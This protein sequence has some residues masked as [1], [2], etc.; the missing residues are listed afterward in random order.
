MRALDWKGRIRRREDGLTP[1]TEYL[2]VG[3]VVEIVEI[4]EEAVKSE[5]MTLAISRVVVVPGRVE[6]GREE[7]TWC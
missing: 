2:A 3:L 1:G 5:G 4:A 7:A 6:A